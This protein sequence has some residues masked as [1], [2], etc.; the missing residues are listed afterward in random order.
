ME[1][2]ELNKIKEMLFTTMKETFKKNGEVLP[3]AVIIKQDRELSYYPMRFT[4]QLEKQIM[5]QQIKMMCQQLN[6]LAVAIMQEAWMAKVDKKDAD[7]LRK[8]MAEKGIG[9]KDLENKKEIA[10]L[11]FET[12]AGNEMISCDIERKDNTLVNEVRTNEVKGIFSNLLSR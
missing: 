2:E 6:P 10:M 5:T 8:E 12:S 1:K 3:M 4:N 11:L 7:A 9:V